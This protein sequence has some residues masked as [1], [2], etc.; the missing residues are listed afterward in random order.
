MIKK[1][2]EEENNYY[3][4]RLYP[5]QDEVLALLGN[6][7][8]YLTGGT[9]LSRFYYDHRFSEDL[10]FFFDGNRHPLSQFEG[11]FAGFIK[12][13]KKICDIEVTVNGASF[14]RAFCKNDDIYLKLEFIYEPYPRIGE[15]VR[16]ANYF[17]DTK[18]NIA[19]NK[20]TAIYTRKTVKDYFDL[21]FLLKE[22]SLGDLLEQTKIKIIPPAF[23]E[24]I[25][26]LKETIF[27]GEVLTDKSYDEG[28]FKKFIETLIM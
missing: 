18:E 4:N 25:I 11:E 1:V 8:F 23:E 28:E 5:L 10:D 21:Y 3:R 26:S 27:E 13:I 22:Y 15:V 20:L 7:L 17:I 2:S 9:C 19:V 14:K 12:K 24:L 6:E 16:E